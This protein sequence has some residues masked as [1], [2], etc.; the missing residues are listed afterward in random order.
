MK[1]KQF[2]L[3]KYWAKDLQIQ[4]KPLPL[5]PLSRTKDTKKR[6]EFR[7]VAQSG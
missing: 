1:K 3:K 5:Q 6:K 2:F 7:G 4:E